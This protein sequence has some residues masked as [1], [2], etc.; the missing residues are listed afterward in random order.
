MNSGRVIY[1]LARAD[2]YERVRRYSF[3]VMLGLSIFLSLQVANGNLTLTLDRYRGEFNSAWV[4]AMVSIVATFFIGWFGFYLVKGSIGRDRQTGV[5]QIIATTPLT[6]SLYM[7]GKWLSNLAV[8]AAMVFLLALAGLA[9]QLW[10]GE[11]TQ[12]NLWA[13]LS[14]FILIVLPLIALVA[15]F[16]VFFETIPFLRGGFGNIV[17]FIGF[18]SAFAFILEGTGP[19]LDAFEPLGM[20]LLAKTMGEAVQKVYPDYGGGFSLGPKEFIS[21]TFTWE[22]INWTLDILLARLSLLGLAIAIT[23]LA[24]LLFDRFDPS[25]AKPQRVKTLFS[26]PT[27]TVTAA[28]MALPAIHLTPLKIAGHNFRFFTVLLAELKLLIKGQRWWWYLVAGGLIIACLGNTAADTRSIVLPLA[29]AWPVLIWSSL[30]NRETYHNTQQITFSSYSPLWR[31]LPAQWLAGFMIALLLGSGALLR[32]GIEGDMQGLLAFF[33]GAMFISSLALAC[34]VW[35]GTSKL[36]EVLYVTLLYLGAFNRTPPLDFSGAC[37]NGRPEFFVPIS[38][39][40]I[41]S[42][43]LGRAR[44]VRR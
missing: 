5:G 10:Q 34:G 27:P 19:K 39:V 32:L 18:L 36:F 33:S 25:R 2:F 1:H 21:G 28:S 23:M 22:G 16:A 41:I 3:L 43:F 24:A 29:W 38:L 30:G 13:F 11:N 4:G 6:R 44:Q 7:L 31:Q 12:I 35:S 42:A 40:L 17:Y 20:R 9:I 15:A 37:S 14:P 26:G 8:L